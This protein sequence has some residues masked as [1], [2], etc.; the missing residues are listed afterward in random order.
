M[1]LGTVVLVSG[2]RSFFIIHLATSRSAKIVQRSVKKSQLL[3]DVGVVPT[4]E[5]IPFADIS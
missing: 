1:P 5:V 4:S 2:F 3:R